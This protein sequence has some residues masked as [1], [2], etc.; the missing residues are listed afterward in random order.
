MIL[1]MIQAPPEIPN[2]PLPDPGPTQP[3]PPMPDP[4]PTPDPL[5][6]PYP[7]PEPEPMPIPPQDLPLEINRGS[8]RQLS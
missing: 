2:P 7:I 3:N 8:H 5:P 6:Q 1:M 4:S